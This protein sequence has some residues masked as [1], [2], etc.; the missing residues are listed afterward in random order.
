M[1][2]ADGEDSCMPSPRQHE[3]EERIRADF[4][5]ALDELQRAPIAQ[6]PDAAERLNCAMRRLYDFVGYGKVPADLQLTRS[7]SS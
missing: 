1:R 4:R 2:Y 3:V 5:T 6:R 7:A